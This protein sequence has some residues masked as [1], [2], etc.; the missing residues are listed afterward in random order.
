M[1]RRIG[2]H[3]SVAP[4]EEGSLT[5]KPAPPELSELYEDRIELRI[6]I[7]LLQERDSDKPD[8]ESSTI[9]LADVNAKIRA[10]EASRLGG[11]DPSD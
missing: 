4:N 7:A 8:L 6:R 9:K 2:V 10:L 11:S 1:L 5:R 3:D